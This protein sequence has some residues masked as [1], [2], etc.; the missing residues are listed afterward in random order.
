MLDV[1]VCAP[2]IE[3]KYPVLL[4]EENHARGAY[5]GV[6]WNVSSLDSA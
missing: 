4:P 2:D 3:G 1:A 5:L 6:I